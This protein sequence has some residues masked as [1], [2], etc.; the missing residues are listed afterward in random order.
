MSVYSYESFL[1]NKAEKTSAKPTSKFQKVGYFKLEND[2]DSA[3][4]RFAYK[5]K[6]EFEI[7]TVHVVEGYR[8]VV[9]LRD[10]K[11]PVDKCPLCAAGEKLF[12]KFYVKL[13][14]YT[15]DAEG[16]VVVTPKV[17]ERPS[18]FART[19][20][21]LC[22][23]YGADLCDHVFKVKRKGAKNDTGT[24]YDVMYA[25]PELYKES[26]GYVKD[27]S[28]FNNFD[29]SKHSYYVKS[30]EEI[31]EYCETGKF[32]AVVKTVEE[33]KNLDKV[34]PTKEAETE[35]E[36]VVSEPIPDFLLNKQTTTKQTTTGSPATSAVDNP[37][38]AVDNPYMNKEFTAFGSDT[39]NVVPGTTSS[40]PTFSRPR[41]TPQS[42]IYK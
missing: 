36:E 22:E 19:L 34:F 33:S 7:A 9:C 3:L 16:N 15:K 31:A 37:Y 23:E 6:S 14:E 24:T 11:D 10:A 4:V 13:I 41:R 40:D 8:R 39:P 20:D 35:A 28:A 42:D 18:S 29:L 21:S 17:W 30:F 25:N 38:M 27:F 1:M 26:I 12:S 5:D 2:G 32:P